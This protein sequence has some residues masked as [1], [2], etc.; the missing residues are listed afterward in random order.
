MANMLART[1]AFSAIMEDSYDGGPTAETTDFSSS[2][3]LFRNTNIHQANT[4]TVELDELQ[5]SMS[6]SG[7]AVG[8]QLQTF[9]PGYVLM[10]FGSTAAKANYRLG[11]IFRMCGMQETI[12][13]SSLTYKFRSTGFESGAVA[14]HENAVSGNGI[15]YTA[16]GV[17]GSCQLAGA[18]GQVITVDPT[19]QGLY[20]APVAQAAP[21]LINPTDGNIAETMKSEALVITPQGESAKSTLTFKSFTLDFGI[22]VQ[23]NSDANATDALAGLLI[24]NRT[25][26]ATVVVGL[27]S[28]DAVDWFSHLTTGSSK[29]HTV[30]FTHSATAQQKVKFTWIGQL[31]DLP[32]A[33]D[34]GQRT[35]TLTYRLIDTANN[36]GE[37]Q[38]DCF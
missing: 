20:A 31:E 28:S 1:V 10:G 21:T 9:T 11:R 2:N 35:V 37:L 24:V 8:R 34:V 33:D 16:T 5:T 3:F 14:L 29:R 27:D 18:A 38:I 4:N 30:T 22:D 26:R 13:T 6:K 23:E 25:A 19:L 32:K 7:F 36:D 17:Y 12:P 15:L